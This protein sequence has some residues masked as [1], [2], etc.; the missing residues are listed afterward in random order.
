[1]ADQVLTVAL[2]VVVLTGV[3]AVLAAS[4]DRPR[5]ADQGTGARDRGLLLVALANR[6]ARRR[7]RA[8]GRVRVLLPGW[9][10]PIPPGMVRVGDSRR[11]SPVSR[12]SWRICG[13]AQTTC[14]LPPR[15]AARLAAAG[16][17]RFL[18]PLSPALPLGSAQM[19]LRRSFPRSEI[20]RQERLQRGA[21][22][23]G[24]RKR[25]VLCR[26]TLAMFLTGTSPREFGSAEGSSPGTQ[27]IGGLP[28]AGSSGPV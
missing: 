13:R 17:T 25:L 1:V 28:A 12:N 5:D 23:D 16:Q 22:P 7:N 27:G 4:H 24:E 19:I 20:A 9:H 15:A 8:P 11:S 10:G 3:G 2:V 14:R 18:A 21:Q 6:R 26:S